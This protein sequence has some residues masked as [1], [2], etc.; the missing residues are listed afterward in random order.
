MSSK[1]LDLI[2]K[3][4]QADFLTDWGTLATTFK[5]RSM[6]QI[7]AIL[8][9]FNKIQ[10]IPEYLNTVS[11]EVKGHQSV[12]LNNLSMFLNPKDY[13]NLS[14]SAKNI[15]LNPNKRRLVPTSYCPM[16]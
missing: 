1:E 14:M 13:T 2:I 15:I 4:H 10:S 12:C 3:L 11:L 5:E 16:Q 8:I 7:E 9:F 6:S